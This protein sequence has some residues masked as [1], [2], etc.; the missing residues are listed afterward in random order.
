MH[1]EHPVSGLG[2][3]LVWQI[4]TDHCGLCPPPASKK[5]R[6]K[7]WNSQLP[8]H[9]NQ[10]AKLELP[11][12]QLD[13]NRRL[14]QTWHVDISGNFWSCTNCEVHYSKKCLPPSHLHKHYRAYESKPLGN[15]DH[16]CIYVHATSIPGKSR[17]QMSR[18]V[19]L[20][21]SLKIKLAGAIMQQD[22]HEVYAVNGAHCFSHKVC[23]LLIGLEL[24]APGWIVTLFINPQW[25]LIVP[26]NKRRSTP[27]ITGYIQNGVIVGRVRGSRF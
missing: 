25:V 9:R 8:F 4:S 23:E 17:I 13:H 22:F 12:S 14:Q 27:C 18:E 5:Q 26:L 19:S 6:E 16:S 10:F 15:N 20:H 1:L 21:K 24:T 7:K 11:E 3:A 2:K